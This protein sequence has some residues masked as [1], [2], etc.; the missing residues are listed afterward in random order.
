MATSGRW[1]TGTLL[2][3][4]VVIVGTCVSGC[5]SRHHAAVAEPGTAATTSTTESSPSQ[6][7][8]PTVTEPSHTAPA[9]PGGVYLTRTPCAA[10]PPAA[11]QA[12]VAHGTL[13][14]AATET[15]ASGAPTPDED[16]VLDQ[17]NIGS[18]A[19]LALV[20]TG[21]HVLQTVATLPNANGA[22]FGFTAINASYVAFVYSLTNGQDAQSHWDLY[23]FNRA[24]GRLSLV[25]HN[26]HDAA[27]T[28]LPSDWV[29]PILTDHY[30]Y[31]LQAAH[32][33]PPWGGSELQQYN[34]ATGKLRTLYRGLVRAMT[35]IGHTVL[36][37]AVTA[38]PNTTLAD[39]PM[40]VAALA[41]DSGLPVNPPAGITAGP[42]GAFTLQYSAGTLIWNTS[43]GTLRAWRAEWAKSITIV[44][45]AQDWPLAQKLGMSGPAYPRIYHQFVIWQPGNTWVLDLKTNSFVVLSTNGG[46]GDLSG[47][48]MSIEQY[49]TAVKTTPGHYVFDQ[50]VFD[51]SP[52]PDFAPCP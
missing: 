49:T 44:P 2:L 16:A 10:T 26:P 9:V 5:T 1:Q 32:T 38:H 40:T 3:A 13:W 28:P 42:D 34:L 7:A 51:L 4:C 11:W 48:R 43:A 6:S 12:A 18:T 37:T 25:T 14:K 23:L 17:T 36:Y 46:G 27:G 50:A 15:N 47:S 33:A 24:T 20:G 29:Q 19:E 35:V 45:T 52:L 31:W 21:H 30:L 39:P 22:Q 8:R 41:Q